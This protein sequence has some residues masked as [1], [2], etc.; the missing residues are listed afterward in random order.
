MTETP[1]NSAVWTRNEVDSPCQKICVI[2]PKAR[3]C[4]G[5]LRTVDEISKWSRMTPD[6]RRAI[7][8]TLDSR[9]SQLATRRGGRGARMRDG[10][11]S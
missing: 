2:H 3:L 5:C 8:D 4:V 10:D 6:A 11:P 9:R 7:M 1:R